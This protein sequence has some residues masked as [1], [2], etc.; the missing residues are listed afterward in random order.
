MSES[1]DYESSYFAEYIKAFNSQHFYGNTF[2]LSP[3][4]L[5]TS[6]KDVN[7]F[8][9][10]FSTEQI[11]RMVMQP[12]EY[13]EELR[14]LSYFNFNTVGLY[15][16]IITL[17]SK[18]LTFDW[19]PIPYTEDG[20]PITATEFRSKDYKKDYAELT[21]FFNNF[22]VKEEFSKVLWNLCMY[23]TYFT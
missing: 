6:L 23:D 18:M 13:E 2:M 17:W 8:S 14:K 22:K 10:F 15:R 9:S 12:H 21:K 19:N 7:M 16:Q 1:I 20:K 5:N 11:R 3:Q 4:M